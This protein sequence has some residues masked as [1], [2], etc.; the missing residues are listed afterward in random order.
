MPVVCSSAPKDSTVLFGS[1]NL[2]RLRQRLPFPA[3]HSEANWDLAVPGEKC[4]RERNFSCF[5]EDYLI[6]NVL[7][8]ETNLK[9]LE[10]WNLENWSDERLQ[11][12]AAQADP[13]RFG[14]LYENNFERVYAYIAR[15]VRDREEV[16]DLTSEVFHLL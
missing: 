16:Q 14:E 1:T 15:R 4:F 9:A 3:S 10:G 8:G 6:K 2:R 7:R 11:N 12:E 5:C 13:A